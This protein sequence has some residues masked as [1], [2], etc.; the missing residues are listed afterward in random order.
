M[1]G[2]LNLS[3]IIS[4]INRATAPIR[5][6]TNNFAAMKTAASQASK[7]FEVAGNIRQA[8]EG[9]KHFGDGIQSALAPM[10]SGFESFGAEMARV[11]MFTK[12]SSRGMEELENSIIGVSSNIGGAMPVDV[13]RGMAEF[14]KAGFTNAQILTAMPTALSVAKV[15]QS[16]LGDTVRA[17]TGIMGA[18][19]LSASQAGQ[20]G[21]VMAVAT[22]KSRISVG[23]LGEVLRK[24][25]NT[26]RETKT[27]LGTAA[28]M[29]ALLSDAGVDA[30]QSTLV[31]RKAMIGLSGGAMGNTKKV[32]DYLG[33]KP[34]GN[35]VATL[36]QLKTKIEALPEEKQTKALTYLFGERGAQGAAALFANIDE[37]KFKS[38]A[39]G[40]DHSQGS[41]AEISAIMGGT[42]QAASKTL[43][44]QLAQLNIALG[45]NLG[46]T[47]EKGTKRLI[48]IIKWVKE[49]T[50]AHPKLT[51]TILKGALVA[52]T[53]ATVL[54]G[55][56]WTLSTIMSGFG[57]LQMA[58]G[59]VKTAVLLAK[60][61]TLPPALGS[62]AASAWAAAAPF[63]A[64]AA[65]IAAVSLAI[66]ELVKHW[67]DI[68]GLSISDTI[69]GIGETAT[70]GKNLKEMNFGQGLAATMTAPFRLMGEMLNPTAMLHDVKGM[71]TSAMPSI[72]TPAI[73]GGM[74]K[75]GGQID[76]K[77][78]SDRP[79]TVTKAQ[80]SGGIDLGI[81][82]GMQTVGG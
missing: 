20:V 3:I 36:G 63:V 12:N 48:G 78:H 82:T 62:V 61:I 72:T 31:L 28:A 40:I 25:G 54:T 5:E 34:S 29:A 53:L 39:E 4:A 6:V 76:L 26:A 73:P 16:D 41:L 17:T 50:T 51:S 45:E 38:L 49:W 18:F 44:S 15:A 70:G 59:A 43:T 27:G 52:G 46:P 30:G 23:D 79:V 42:A 57:A 32:L 77:I 60:L 80:A 33:V 11:Q 10:I 66:A 64:V 65:A 22:T 7:S 8:G 1:P 37:G 75:V 81:D 68:K 71:M 58:F 69:K 21:D 56:M 9:V 2:D 13:A 35:L 24:V 55:V 74:Q 47:L 14:G 19:G 67:E